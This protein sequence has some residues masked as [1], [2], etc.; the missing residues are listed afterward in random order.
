MIGYRQDK[1]KLLTT[2]NAL[3]LGKEAE[4]EFEPIKASLAKYGQHYLL[5]DSVGD[6]FIVPVNIYN[7][8]NLKLPNVTE[9]SKLHQ[10]GY[11]K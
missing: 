1:E 10:L 8:S 11:L 2:K 7:N 9:Y 6:L 4:Q 5:Q 3:N